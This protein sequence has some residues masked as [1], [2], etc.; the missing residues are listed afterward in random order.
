MNAFHKIIAV[1]GF[2]DDGSPIKGDTL[3]SGNTVEC[4]AF[5]MKR[6][7]HGGLGSSCDNGRMVWDY[8]G[9]DGKVHICAV[10][11]VRDGEANAFQM[12]DRKVFSSFSF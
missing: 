1:T 5:M 9:E 6:W 7:P 8:R 12:G 11:E 2:G 10:V 4:F 3:F